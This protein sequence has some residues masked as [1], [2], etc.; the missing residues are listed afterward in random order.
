MAGPPRSRPQYQVTDTFI[1]AV[2][3]ERA[4]G[5]TQK[6]LCRLVGLP[7]PMLSYWLHRC[8]RGHQRPHPD[9]QRLRRLA[10]VL[11]LPIDACVEEV[12]SRPIS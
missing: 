8:Y 7:P 12:P 3:A 6:D 5:G 4:A 1:A 9:D 10:R 11:D 2:R